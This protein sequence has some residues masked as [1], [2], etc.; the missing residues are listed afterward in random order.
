[1]RQREEAKETIKYLQTER[2]TPDPL[3]G[4]NPKKRKK[5]KKEKKHL[6]TRKNCDKRHW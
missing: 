3:R 6:N 4:R 2:K 1:M 5:G